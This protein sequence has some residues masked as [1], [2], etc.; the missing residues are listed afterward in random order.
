MAG[1]AGAGAAA[2]C[3][4]ALLLLLLFFCGVKPSSLMRRL[5]AR[6]AT[7][8]AA[9]SPTEEAQSSELSAHS[10]STLAATTFVFALARLALSIEAKSKAQAWSW[11]WRWPEQK[12]KP[13]LQGA[14]R[15]GRTR[16]LNL[17]PASQQAG[18]LVATARHAAQSAR[19][20]ARSGDGTAAAAATHRHSKP[21]R[22]TF[23]RQQKQRPRF[24][25]RRAG[26]GHGWASYDQRQH[27]V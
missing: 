7:S 20:C 10:L 5:P 26:K 23:F 27:G 3:A 4:C 25:C 19:T 9:T 17:G 15:R 16:K 22:P 12:T 13:H 24:S 11:A 21:S 8:H 2:W 1:E 14:E 6:R 18:R